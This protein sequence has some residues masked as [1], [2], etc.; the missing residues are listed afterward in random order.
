[1]DENDIFGLF[2]HLRYIKE[3]VKD[4]REL[5]KKEYPEEIHGILVLNYL[6]NHM[7]DFI[8]DE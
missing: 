5:L 4:Q 8:E 7:L 1:M 3:Y 2:D 6:H